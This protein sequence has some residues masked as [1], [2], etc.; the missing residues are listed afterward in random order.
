MLFSDSKFLPIFRDQFGLEDIMDN[1]NLGRERELALHMLR[2]RREY[3]CDLRWRKRD[4]YVDN[5]GKV[6]ENGDP[7]YAHAL[8]IKLESQRGMEIKS[9]GR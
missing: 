3:I 4:A 5:S 6:I 2:S 9:K 7:F 8:K 1:P